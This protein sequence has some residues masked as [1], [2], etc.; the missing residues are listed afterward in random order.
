MS[1][2]PKKQFT[3]IKKRFQS[4]ESLVGVEKKVKNSKET[5]PPTTTSASP[6]SMAFKKFSGMD[7]SSSKS[8]NVSS[9]GNS[10]TQ[11]LDKGF[12]SDLTFDDIPQ[13]DKRLVSTLIHDCKFTSLTI[14]QSQTIVPLLEGN[15]LHLLSKTGSGKTGAFLVPSIQK[16]L[17]QKQTRNVQM[18]V[19]SPTRELALQIAKEATMF[20]AKLHLK[21][22][23]AIGGTNINSERNAI[24]NGLNILIATPGRLLDHLSSGNFLV[25]IET[26]VLDECDR[27][28][29]MGFKPDIQKIVAMLP[30]SKNRQNILC[31]ATNTTEVDVIVK[32][33][34]K[35]TFLKVSTIPEGESNVHEKIPQF[36]IEAPFNDHLSTC[37]ALL[38]QEC[39]QSF[40]AIVFLPTAHQANFYH[41]V[42]SASNI[43]KNV[44]V[45][46]SRQA[47]SKRTKVTQ[48]F[49]NAHQAIL[50]ATDVVARG[51][52]FPN[53]S[54]VFQVGVPDDAPTYIHRVGRTGRAGKDGKGF[55]IL[56]KS[57]LFLLPALK[58][59]KVPLTKIQ[60]PVISP[61]IL[62]V[63]KRGIQEFLRESRD[64]ATKVYQGNFGLMFSN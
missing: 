20:S 43:C 41:A 64:N 11:S 56:D 61:A 26:F 55:S 37:L 25:S 12:V 13:L 30:Q 3:L 1:A 57:E 47:Q 54:H 60:G 31:S 44:Y 8:L 38:K 40:K 45:Q 7:L 32:T 59:K 10:S 28:L 58:A 33:L 46:H 52:D 6:T 35:P 14:A 2:A 53:V 48:D 51:M 36:L 17:L 23:V 29:D 63:E 34:L 27:L 22:G 19:I 50:F 62:D 9:T 24:K 39:D 15:D 5:P 42:C 21:I 16:I 49:K 18:L 4:Q